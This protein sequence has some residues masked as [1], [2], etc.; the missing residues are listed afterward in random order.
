MDSGP[1]TIDTHMGGARH[2]TAVF[3]VAADRTA[4]IDAGPA[5]SVEATLDELESAGVDHLDWVVLTHA[6]LDHAGAAGHLAQRFPDAKVAA[7]ERVCRHL[8][9]PAALYAGTRHVWGAR[10]DEL[11]GEPRAID[12]ARLEPLGDGSELDLG[13]SKLIALATPGHTRNH[14]SYLDSASH[15]VLCG[16]ALGLRLPGSPQARPASPPADFSLADALQSIRRIKEIG[17]RDLLLSHFGSVRAADGYESP[18]AACDAASESLERWSRLVIRN[19]ITDAPCVRERAITRVTQALVPAEESEARAAWD[20]LEAVNPVW[21]N[22]D[23][24]ER[25]LARRLGRSPRW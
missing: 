10:T 8:A 1:L 15:T 21:L 9:D 25:E 18:E 14:L 5:A 24:L 3:V 16:D 12:P 19:L 22:V 20:R 4:L 17:A 13:G 11:I 6:H 2:R 7:P 23:G